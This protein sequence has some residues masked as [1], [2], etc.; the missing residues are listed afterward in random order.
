MFSAACVLLLFAAPAAAQPGA[1]AP[2][3]PA[4]PNVVLIVA[5]DKGTRFS[6]E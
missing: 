2:G 1:N 4:R 3:S 5:D 6:G